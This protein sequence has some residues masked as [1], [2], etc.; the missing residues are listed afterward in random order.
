VTLNS[1]KQ[2]GKFRL[3]CFDNSFEGWY[4]IIIK[5]TLNDV[6]K[7]AAFDADDPV[8]TTHTSSWVLEMVNP[9]R[10]TN[11]LGQGSTFASSEAKP[12]MITTV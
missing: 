5:A 12:L 9:C 11:I 4:E 8:S 2:P 3:E 7:N 1:N 10:I 6:K